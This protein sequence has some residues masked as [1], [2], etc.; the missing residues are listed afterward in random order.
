MPLSARPAVHV[1]ARCRVEQSPLPS[2]RD[3][4][5]WD[6]APRRESATD[7]EPVAGELVVTE[8][9]VEQS[10]SRLSGAVVV[11]DCAFPLL[12][13]GLYLLLP[14]SGWAT[15]MFESWF[16]QGRDLE[17]LRSLLADGRA[18]AIADSVIGP[19]YI[20]AAALVHDVFGLSPED[21]L[22]ALTRASYAL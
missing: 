16:D 7:V 17:A 10:A 15:E 3:D 18:D 22:V 13:L 14:V 5:R 1:K 6:R 19:A 21:S 11:L 20:G 9:V 4:H 12:W 2:G 8:G